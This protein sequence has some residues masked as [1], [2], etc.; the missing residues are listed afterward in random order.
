[1]FG[2]R[3]IAQLAVAVRHP[4]QRLGYNCAIFG[5][6]GDNLLVLLDRALQIPL[7]RFGLHRGSQRNLRLRLL[8]GQRAH[9]GQ[10]HERC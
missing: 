6:Y 2:R 7:D 9:E 8:R 4:Q 1:M 5:V 3:G 10:D